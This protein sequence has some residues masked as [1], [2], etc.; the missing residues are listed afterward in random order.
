M[1]SYKW[2]LKIFNEGAAFVA[3]DLETTGLNPHVDRIAEIGAVKF[4]KKGLVSRFSTLINPGIPMPAEASRVNKITDKMLESKPDI[5]T[6]LP[7]FLKFI[8][9]T[10]IVAHN[11]PFDCGFIKEALKSGLVP[12]KS[13]PNPIVDTLILS[14][15]KIPGLKSYS[16]EKL[17]IELGISYKEVHRAED[18]AFICMAI[19]LYCMGLVHG[20]ETS[21]LHGTGVPESGI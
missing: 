12:F 19:F 3:F 2:A 11:A 13:L 15:E 20:A 14:R 21:R 5:D 9:N 17:A 6:I 10:V 7:D 18:D 1:D 16:L 8:E 4:D